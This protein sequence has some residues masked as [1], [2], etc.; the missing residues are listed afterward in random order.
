M[1]WSLTENTPGR[2]RETRKGRGNPA[3]RKGSAQGR[4]RLLKVSHEHILDAMMTT[5]QA[6]AFAIFAPDELRPHPRAPAR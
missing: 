5:P 1:P 3:A 2:K 4:S 6:G